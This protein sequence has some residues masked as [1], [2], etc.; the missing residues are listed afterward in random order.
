MGSRLSYDEF[1]ALV[2]GT[3]PAEEERRIRERCEAD[4]ALK[5]DL[6]QFVEVQALTAPGDAPP[7]PCP[8]DFEAVL[9]ALAP[10]RAWRMV[11]RR[12]W[13]VAAAVLVLVVGGALLALAIS[14]RQNRSDGGEAGRPLLLAAIPP[15]AEAPAESGPDVPA[16]LADYRPVKEGRVQWISSLEAAKAVAQ[17]TARPV[18]LFVYHPSCPVCGQMEAVTFRDTEVLAQFEGFVPARENVVNAPPEVRRLLDEGFPWLGALDTTGRLLL[19]FPGG[20]GPV[21]FLDRLTA[22]GRLAGPSPLT[23][24]KV[25]E[26]LRRLADAESAEGRGDLAAA[27]AG[28]RALAADVGGLPCGLRARA[29]LA[30]LGAAARHALLAARDAAARDDLPA[31]RRMLEDA[32]AR[33]AGTPYAADLAAVRARLAATSR[34]PDIAN[35]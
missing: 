1:R 22:A 10:R 31:A 20:R 34:F 6:E 5:A 28:F 8:L 16:M 2:S 4:P 24:E 9:G 7:P 30:R 23:W 11:L 12:T 13:R 35:L 15:A 19:S 18:L 26:L 33:F 32:A 3:L 29:G 25:H 27:D 14:D 17:A 21:E